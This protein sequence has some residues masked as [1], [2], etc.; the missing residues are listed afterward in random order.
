MVLGK[1]LSRGQVTLPGAVRRAAG[2]QAD[3]V[4]AFE[5]TGPGLVEIRRLPRLTLVE[6]LDRYRIDGVIDLPAD[7]A[8]W[9]AKA[10]VD[11][12]GQESS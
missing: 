6:A 11:V 9:E 7:R 5:V 8:A 3:D 12:L 2:I 10:A 1:V 4:V